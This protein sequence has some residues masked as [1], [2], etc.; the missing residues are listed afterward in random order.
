M[1]R[2]NRAAGIRYQGVSMLLHDP[3]NANLLALLLARRLERALGPAG[4]PGVARFP[5]GELTIVAGE[6]VAR[7]RLG[8]RP[9]LVSGEAGAGA[10]TA[11]ESPPG[12]PG[13]W[14]RARIEGPLDVLLGAVVGE[15]PIGAVLSGEL[16]VSGSMRLCWVALRLLRGTGP[17]R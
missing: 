5:E 17:T 1:L 4:E 8:A 14:R 12:V 15:L 10:G 16:K 3:E 6:M 11:G 13:D 9:H 7:L 2:Q